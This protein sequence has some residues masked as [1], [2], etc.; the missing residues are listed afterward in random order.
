MARLKNLLTTAFNVRSGEGLPL[1]LL[2]LHSFSHGISMVFLETPANTLFL[3]AF[4]AKSLPYVYI[5]T[6]IVSTGLGYAYTKLEHRASRARLL[7]G[8]LAFIAAITTLFYVALVLFRS[9]GL[10]MG[11]MVWREVAWVLAGLEIWALAGFLFNVRQGKRLFALVGAGEVTAGIVG[12]LSVPV[13]VPLIG[14]RNLLLVSALGTVASLAVLRTILRVFDERFAPAPGQQEPEKNT[15]PLRVLF[16]ERYLRSFFLVSV[17]ACLTFYF[18]DYVFYDRVEG[19]FPDETRLASFFGFYYA[20]LSFADLVSSALLSGR[21]MMRYGLSFGLLAL[22]IANSLGTGSAIGSHLLI[23]AGAAFLWFVVATKL[24]DEVVRSSVQSHAFRILYQPLPVAKRLQIQAIRESVIEPVAI[25]LSGVILLLLTSVFKFDALHI[26][27]VVLVIL[28]A[29]IVGSFLLRREYTKTLLTAMTK[30]RLRDLSISLE[31]PSTLVIVNKGLASAQATE[32][33]YCL[34]VLEVNEHESLHHALIRLLDHPDATVRRAAL[35]RIEELRVTEA[36]ERLVARLDHETSPPVLA[37]LLRALCAVGDAEIFETVSRYLS[38]AEPAVR[39]GAI[40]G[41]L[42]SGG[43]DGVLIAGAHLNEL[44]ASGNAA[45]RKLAAQVL[46]DVGIVNFYQPLVKLLRDDDLEV[47]HAALAAAAHVRNRKLL[48]LVF[49][50]LHVSQVREAASDALVHYGDDAIPAIDRALLDKSES[51]EF[52]ARLARICGHIPG[53]KSIE[54]LERHMTHSDALI[55]T[56]VIH[57]LALCRHH[58]KG[59]EIRRTRDA[60]RGEVEGAAWA[61]GALDD[62]PLDESTAP[63]RGA[64][65]LEVAKARERVLTFL[66]FLYPSETLLEV[67]NRLS[68]SSA[69]KRAGALELLDNLLTQDLKALTF[70]LLDDLT[71]QERLSRLSV[72]FPQ[73][74]LGAQERL[75]EIVS[76][77]SAGSSPWTRACALDAIGI[78]RRSELNPVL[79]SALGDPELIVRETAAWA[80]FQCGPALYRQHCES[81]RADPDHLVHRTMRIVESKGAGRA[82]RVRKAQG[83]LE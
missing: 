46:G 62:L 5:L 55:R 63:L 59:S 33:L 47:R 72:E 44:L 77:S 35:E 21:L 79:V 81:L 4:S 20:G 32:V 64:L 19:A 3:G 17:L 52:R 80:L 57:S 36:R 28:A 45:D 12:G 11:L 39:K 56:Q 60:I 74:R 43:I 76:G 31:D 78:S 61:L 69:E 48:P 38:D 65:A 58:A 1:L 37:H 66:S 75:R 67:K 83:S 7:S 82:R 30:K 26:L 40:G 68:D 10:T 16:H 73:R 70:S 2:L 8:M 24:L 23:G 71:P 13:I 42:R 25:G 9:S 18:I 49:E 14:T 53:K 54:V 41:L 51:R 29:W 15:G 34:H 27:C 22:P 50:N 6:A